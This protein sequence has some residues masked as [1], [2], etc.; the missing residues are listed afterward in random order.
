MVEFSGRKKVVKV[1]LMFEDMLVFLGFLDFVMYG[2]L[3]WDV[4]FN[5]DGVGLVDVDGLAQLF[6][7]IVWDAD[8]G[9]DWNLGDVVE[10]DLLLRLVWHLHPHVVGF[11]V[12]D[13]D[14]N[15]V[16]LLHDLPVLLV[17]R[18]FLVLQVLESA[19]LASN[20]L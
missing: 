12:W 1:V 4:S 6:V 15:V 9:G 5:L 16:G 14:V 7:V 3:Y 11:L 20:P 17:G 18:V 8:C 2:N 10:G 13:P 19:L